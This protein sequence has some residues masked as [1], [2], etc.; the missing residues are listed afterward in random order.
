MYPTFGNCE[1]NFDVLGTVWRIWV[2]CEC[3]CDN[4]LN[5]VT[6]E[7]L[8][9]GKDCPLSD[10]PH[11]ASAL[12][13]LASVIEPRLACSTLEHTDIRLLH[14]AKFALWLELSCVGCLPRCC[15]VFSPVL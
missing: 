13:C 15:L 4:I 5:S 11:H 14:F 9:K 3:E 10:S 1:I 7:Q 8:T 12:H 2:T 6:D